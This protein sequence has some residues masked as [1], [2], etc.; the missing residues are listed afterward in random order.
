MEEA[1]L[2]RLYSGQPA[3]KTRILGME[4][5][6]LLREIEKGH[7]IASNHSIILGDLKFLKEAAKEI[8]SRIIFARPEIILTPESKSIYLAGKIGEELGLERFEVC[9]KATKAYNKDPVVT[10][11]RSTISGEERLILDGTSHDN[12]LGKRIALIDDVVTTG[13]NMRGM[14]K[15]VELSHGEVVVKA[16]IW[17]EGLP[18]S[19][20]A[21]RARENL[22]YLS[23][24]PEFFAQNKLETAKMN[25]RSQVHMK[26]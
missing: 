17:V 10:T 23:T 24:L 4:R 5:E 8:A 15:L 26:I 13:G 16:C 14:E 6:L 9:R 2:L 12:L 20:E 25:F 18:L 19:L 21:F 3:F 22:I 11:I 1:N 7:W